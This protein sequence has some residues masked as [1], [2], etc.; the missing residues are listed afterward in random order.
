MARAAAVARAARAKAVVRARAAGARA[1]CAPTE[2]HGRGEL[3]T[4]SK[5]FAERLRV[6]AVAKAV[7]KGKIKIS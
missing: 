7:E 1:Q 4:K 5:A 2:E 3:C 6:S